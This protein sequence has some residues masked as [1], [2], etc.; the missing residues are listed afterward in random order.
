[1]CAYARCAVRSSCLLS[2]AA[3]R[4]AEG[5]ICRQPREGE[6]SVYPPLVHFP[7]HP[8]SPGAA[9]PVHRVQ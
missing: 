1:V 6:G 4:R 8:L 9:M 2:Y 3:L 7:S 5:A